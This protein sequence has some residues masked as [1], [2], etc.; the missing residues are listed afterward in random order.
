MT[1]IIEF[2]ASQG[3]VFPISRASAN[4]LM[5]FFEQGVFHSLTGKFE[6]FEDAYACAMSEMINEA[7]IKRY[8][9]LDAEI[10]EELEDSFIRGFVLVRDAIAHQGLSKRHLKG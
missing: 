9:A 3:S 10:K 6:R 4:D 8:Q 5:S 7:E 1:K 2:P